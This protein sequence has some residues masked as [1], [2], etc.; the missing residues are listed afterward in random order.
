MLRNT[1]DSLSF[2]KVTLL[3]YSFMD[4][5]QC[6]LSH[7]VTLMWTKEPFYI[8]ER[9]CEH[10]LGALPTR[11]VCSLSELLKDS[12]SGLRLNNF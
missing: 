4:S 10:R 3:W 1:I 9:P 12:S 8:L 2:A 7:R 6:L 11:S 5:L